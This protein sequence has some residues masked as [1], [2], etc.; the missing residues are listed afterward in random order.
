MEK[1]T[2]PRRLSEPEPLQAPYFEHLD[3]LATTLSQKSQQQ[4]VFSFREYNEFACTQCG[5]CCTLPWAINVSKAYYEQWNAHWNQHPDE[6]YHNPFI[7]LPNAKDHDFAAIRRQ[8]NSHNCIFLTE[9][10]RCTIHAE[11]GEEALAKVCRRYPRTQKLL[12]APYAVR[13]MLPSCEAVPPMYIAE[14]E[15]FVHWEED[16][17]LPAGGFHANT[18]PGELVSPL[19]HRW[20]GI[21]LDVLA[22][23]HHSPLQSFARLSFALN[24][25]QDL[26][27]PR[28][29]AQALRRI[30]RE[31]LNHLQQPADIPLIPRSQHRQSIEWFLGLVGH[32]IA[33][34]RAY[35]QGL[36]SGELPWPELAPDEQ[37][38]LNRFMAS[39]LRRRLITMSYIDVF[40]G[41][42]NL[43]QQFFAMA[44]FAQ[45]LQLFAIQAR[46]ASGGPL[47]PEHLYQ[48]TNQV[49][50][51]MGQRRQ[52]LKEQNISGLSPQECIDYAITS[53]SLDFGT[54]QWIV[55]D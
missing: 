20:I 54:T 39:Y 52:W 33:P 23:P 27:L 24:Y 51:R 50:S 32:R 12:P 3:Q 31:L 38:L 28:I 46:A 9:D 10:M 21:V 7:V 40:F 13:Y 48:A 8:P 49:E 2:E 41:R 35:Y 53:L 16:L 11:L 14:N 44:L 25:L 15:V 37:V 55:D 6:K 4:L 5:L 45:A 34:I 1:Q 22:D 17:N 36:L 43:Y 42:I 19:M 30:Y 26:P 29:D 18:P 47:Q